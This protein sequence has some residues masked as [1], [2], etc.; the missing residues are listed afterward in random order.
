MSTRPA[1]SVRRRAWLAIGLIL[2]LGLAVAGRCA[3][4]DGHERTALAQAVGRFHP[5]IVHLPIALLAL[6]PVLELAGRSPR[7]THLR[8]SAG[9]V[10][11][12]AVVA[13]FV[14]A[15]DGWLLARSGGYAGALV[16]RHLWGGVGLA[17]IGLAAAGLRGER[18]GRPGLAYHLVLLAALGTLLWTS[19]QG[20]SL[21]HGEGYLTARWPEPVRAWLGM[22]APA[23]VRQPGPPTGP[24]ATLYAARIQPILQKSCVSC[25]G[26]AKVRGGLR[27]DTYA[28]LM[29]GGEDGPVVLPWRPEDSDL[30]RRITLPPDDDDFMPSNGRNL[31]TADQIQ[32]LERWVGAGASDREPAEAGSPTRP[33][34]RTKVGPIPGQAAAASAGS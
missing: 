28:A 17:A 16:V 15:I 8:S 10:L 23:P 25:H 21:T 22:N 2:A 18:D 12:L 24:A 19:H 29:A 7:R 5:L 11:D 31:L 26:P 14:A 13:T 1:P 6:V 3:G 30:I 34:P 20:G 4:P 32:L 27:L 33:R 9:F